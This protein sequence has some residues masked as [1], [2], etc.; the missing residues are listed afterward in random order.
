MT[1][2]PVMGADISMNLINAPAPN[3]T[4]QGGMDFK[5]LMNQSEQNLKSDGNDRKTVNTDKVNKTNENSYDTKQVSDN[6]EI[7]EVEVE[8]TKEE[9]TGEEVDAAVETVKAIEE[10]ISEELD[11]SVE[12][13]EAVLETMGLPVVALLDVN[14]LPEVIAEIEGVEDILSFATDQELYGEL[15]EIKDF[16]IENVK[17]L[18]EEI[19]IPVEEF[20]KAIA[21]F[22]IPEEE[23]T[24][25]AVL[26]EEPLVKESD[27]KETKTFDEKIEI[28]VSEDVKPKETKRTAP[29]EETTV[30][31]T[32]TEE[33]V[34]VKTAESDR[35]E[36]RH[37]ERHDS[38]MSFAENLLN[39]VFDKLNETTEAVT[40]TEIDAQRILEQITESIKV[41][42]SNELSE[43][44]LK[45]HPE[46]LGNVSVKI[47]ANHEGI[48][49]AHFTAQNESVKAII[50]SQA[51]VLREALESKGVTVEA[52][53]VAVQS[54]E[55]ERN[56]SDQGK[57]QG[58]EER[59]GRRGVRRINL[60]EDS[61]EVSE[62]P[63]DEILKEMMAQNGNT[64]DYSA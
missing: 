19:G 36:E 44:N 64:I 31:K 35:R 40:Y 4:K 46:S 2:T 33:K 48:L 24:E 42:I 25:E 29:S 43:V 1:S 60:T 50:E 55:F 51:V 52:I 18:A 39:K 58:S 6:K 26:T 12:D 53:E 30:N 17:A 22:E 10:K 59:P 21:E 54:H 56:L 62:N 11:V 7:K 34:P 32:E 20:E 27:V 37:G 9:P 63:D 15:N 3:V 13:I 38:P 45:L 16:T 61:K 5:S 57:R 28:N 14:N 41:D 47:S 49:T 8:V 23:I